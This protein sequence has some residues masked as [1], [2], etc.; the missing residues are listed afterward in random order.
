MAEAELPPNPTELDKQIHQALAGLPTDPLSEHVTNER[1]AKLAH[2]LLRTLALCKVEGRESIFELDWD[3]PEFLEYITN[4]T[5]RGVTR[6]EVTA[7]FE[8]IMNLA[9]QR[10]V[11]RRYRRL[12]D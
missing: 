7:F 5:A 6:E 4:T 9:K 12:R 8:K 10:A 11:Y 3:S 2:A 1:E